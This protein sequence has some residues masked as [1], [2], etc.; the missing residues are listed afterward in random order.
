M[1]IFTYLGAREIEYRNLRGI[2]LIGQLQEEGILNLS[3]GVQRV[4]GRVNDLGY[5]Q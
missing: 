3:K 4:C 2:Q 1:R 5:E